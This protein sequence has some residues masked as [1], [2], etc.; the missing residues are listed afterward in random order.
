MELFNLRLISTAQ[1]KMNKDSEIY[2][3]CTQCTCLLCSD[4]HGEKKLHE[5]KMKI[6]QC[7]SR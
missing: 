1:V 5:S 2:S 6:L 7:L 3:E 4:V